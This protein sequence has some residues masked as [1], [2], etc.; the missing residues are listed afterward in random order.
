MAEDRLV[1]LADVERKLQSWWSTGRDPACG[2]H[3]LS[4]VLD[5]LAALPVRGNDK[6]LEAE[7][8]GPCPRGDK[9]ATAVWNL[10]LEGQEGGWVSGLPPD[11]ATRIDAAINDYCLDDDELLIGRAASSPVVPEAPERET[12]YE[13]AVGRVR[14]LLGEAPPVEAP[15]GKDDAATPSASPSKVWTVGSIAGYAYQGKQDRSGEPIALHASRVATVVAEE[16]PDLFD[17]ALLHDAIEDGPPGTAR[18]IAEHCDPHVWRLVCLLT[19]T[20]DEDYFGYI[21]MLAPNP[22]ARL[23][24]LVDLRDNLS[25][26]RAA[27][28]TDSLR[29]RYEKAHGILVAGAVGEGSNPDTSEAPVPATDKGRERLYD[30]EVEGGGSFLYD[31]CDVG[32]FALKMWEDSD[33]RPITVTPAV[34]VVVGDQEARAEQRRLCDSGKC[35]CG[36][37]ARLADGFLREAV[38]VDQ[39]EA[40]LE[41][42]E[43]EIERL[44]RQ[45]ANSEKCALRE[46]QAQIALEKAEAEVTSLREELERVT[47]EASVLGFAEG[48]RWAGYIHARENAADYPKDSEVVS[49]VMF[50]ARSMS[51]LYPLLAVISKAEPRGDDD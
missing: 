3:H 17:A 48:A 4:D 39:L 37:E 28:L 47:R 38:A 36:Q 20:K 43:R 33:W 2:E 12:P 41:A 26:A 6:A 35:S 34:P 45:L 1:R 31:L 15:D 5:A 50:T 44:R 46:L 13:R 11:A 19:R 21:A 51:D 29:R 10:V 25:P 16:R 24:K 18:L 22:D 8:D 7:T 23:I 14:D 27:G 32:R 30:V 49:R 42:A 40:K 9:L